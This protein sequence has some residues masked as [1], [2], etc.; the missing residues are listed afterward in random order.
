MIL[1]SGAVGGGDGLVE[2]G[3]DVADVLGADGEANHLGRDAGVG[4]L[5]DGELR[6]G[7]GGGMDDE[8]FGVADVGDM[9]C[10]RAL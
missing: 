2:V 9:G 1:L 7:G 4:L 6:V 10:A 8:G 3:E 5:L